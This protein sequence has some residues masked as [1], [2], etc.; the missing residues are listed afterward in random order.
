MKTHGDGDRLSWRPC[1]CS[2]VDTD[3]VRGLGQG[4][5]WGARR[6]RGQGDGRG[7]RR[8]RRDLAAELARVA[9]QPLDAV[10]GSVAGLSCTSAGGAVAFR[11]RE[12]AVLAE[13]ARRLAADAID[14]EPRAAD[15][16]RDASLTELFRCRRPGMVRVAVAVAVG[17]VQ[18]RGSPSPQVFVTQS[19][20]LSQG[21]PGCRSG[22]QI[23]Q[24]RRCRNARPGTAC[25]SRSHPRRCSRRT[26]L[27]SR[28]VRAVVVR[29]VWGS[30][31]AVRRRKYGFKLDRRPGESI[32]EVHFSVGTIF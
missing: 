24:H 6:G 28:N 27:R 25:R 20:S 5:S 12:V 30:A 4:G 16:A 31:L 23:P 1:T 22:T 21:C 8:S 11:T 19:E 2:H 18:R 15:L 9:H 7:A 13:G 26:A 10:R 17:V 14:A 29:S 3:N 32:G